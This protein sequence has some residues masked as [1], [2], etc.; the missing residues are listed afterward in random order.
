LGLPERGEKVTST[1]DDVIQF[2]SHTCEFEGRAVS[3]CSG[4]GWRCSHLAVDHCDFSEIGHVLFVVGDAGGI[5]SRS[6]FFGGGGIFEDEGC[7]DGGLHIQLCGRERGAGH[8]D[9]KEEGEGKRAL[10]KMNSEH[11][12]HSNHEKNVSLRKKSVR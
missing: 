8:R 5:D 9:I 12:K 10:G 1:G 11:A 7:V 4:W 6:G 3:R 2:A